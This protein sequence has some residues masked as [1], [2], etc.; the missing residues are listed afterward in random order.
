MI[1]AAITVTTAVF[2]VIGALHLVTDQGD[3]SAYDRAP[4]CAAGTIQT[5]NCVLRTT[6]NIGYAYASK[7]TGKGAHGYTTKAY[8]EP[9]DGKDQ[10]VVLSSSQD[11]TDSVRY[12]DTMPVLI[13]RDQI[14]RFT[15]QG[16]TRNADENPHHL[17][18]DDL[19]QV[20]LCLIAA[21]FFGRPLIRKLLRSRIAINLR[22]NR[23]PDWTLGWLALITAVAA[24]L[25]A[26]YVVAA[27]ALAGVAVLAA[28]VAWP[29]VPWVAARSNQVPYVV[30][31]RAKARA[32]RKR[33][34]GRRA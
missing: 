32:A 33:Q 34:Q 20:A 2:A 31:S 8:L 7:N 16:R 27:F 11:L 28:S 13:W 25:R 15:F 3:Q 21:A 10:T 9:Q 22:R 14:T 17:V 26:S 5:Q 1:S 30:G 12:G 29:F 6:A 24:I 23:I 18:A 19:S 4:Y